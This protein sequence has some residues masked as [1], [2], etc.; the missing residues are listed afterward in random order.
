M[1]KV[2]R[3]SHR[4]SPTSRKERD[5]RYDAKRRND[6]ELAKAAEIRSTGTWQRFR[7]RFRRRF[8]VCCNPFDL[9]SHLVQTDDIHHIRPVATNPDLAYH[10]SNCAPLCRSCHA[11]V[12]ARERRRWSTRTLFDGWR[13]RYPADTGGRPR[14]VAD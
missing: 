12:E 4:A 3:Y 2:A 5:A 7:R 14:R 10:E 11:R 8:P 1:P 13:E 9:P 6:P